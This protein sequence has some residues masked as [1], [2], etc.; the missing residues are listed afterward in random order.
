MMMM[1]IAGVGVCCETK[2]FI[3][4]YEQESSLDWGLILIR[5]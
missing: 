3:G 1:M 5:Y 2:E 4:K